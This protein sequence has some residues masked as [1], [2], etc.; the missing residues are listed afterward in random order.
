M[1]DEETMGWSKYNLEN[2]CKALETDQEV[3]D[4]KG[5]KLDATAL[6][7]IY[8]GNFQKYASSKPKPLNIPELISQWNS[9]IDI[10]KDNQDLKKSIEELN[11]AIQFFKSQG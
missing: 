4:G 11:E 5:M 10:I 6:Q 7:K 3:Y 1:V 2:V 8:S 9:I